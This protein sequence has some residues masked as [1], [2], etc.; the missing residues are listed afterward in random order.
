MTYLELY[1]EAILKFERGE[2]TLNE[3]KNIIKPLMKEIRTESWIPCSEKKLPKE[4]DGE[5]LIT[6]EGKVTTATYSEFSNTWYI[7]DMC[8]VSDEAPTAWMP[9]PEP[10]RKEENN[11]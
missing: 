6:L 3:Y 10:Y 8:G 1:T 5:V 7:G 9:S 11:V 2:I 4:E